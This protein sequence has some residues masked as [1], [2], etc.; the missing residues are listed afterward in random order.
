MANLNHRGFTL[1]EIIVTLTLLAI[2]GGVVLPYF[3]GGV[4]RGTK[5]L[6]MVRTGMQLTSVME[7][8]TTDYRRLLADGSMPVLATLQTY[9][10]NGNVDS[11]T[12]YYGLY[13]PAVKFLDFDDTTRI[14]EAA[15]GTP[16]ACK[17]LKVTVTLNGQSLTALF[18]E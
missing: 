14:E 5:P 13:T 8:F 15:P 16:P 6:E 17:V 7:R 3:V 9:I 11:S 18:T 10:Q 4:T 1:L 12:P 2:L